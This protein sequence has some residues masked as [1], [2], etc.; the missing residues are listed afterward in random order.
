VVDAVRCAI[1]VQSGMLERNAG[2]PADRRVEFRIGIHLGDVVEEA[3]GDLMGDGVSGLKR[4]R[5]SIALCGIIREMARCFGKPRR[6][7]R[8]WGG[9]KRAWRWRTSLCVSIRK[10]LEVG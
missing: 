10:C 3:D 7:W 8:P 4:P 1:E 6:N 5:K 9:R 2:V